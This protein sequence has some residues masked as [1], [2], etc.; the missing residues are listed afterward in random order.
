MRPLGDLQ[1][2]LRQLSP[3]HRAVIELAF[4]HDLPYKEIAQIMDCP[5]GTVKSRMAYALKH[6]KGLLQRKNA[7]S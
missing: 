6:L 5:A 3:E 2:A 4:H 1:A 7:Q